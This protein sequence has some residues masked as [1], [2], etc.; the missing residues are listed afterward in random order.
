MGVRTHG[1]IIR[2]RTMGRISM[3]S[4]LAKL[5]FSREVWVIAVWAFAALC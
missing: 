2:N 5:A 1:V 4:L 3:S